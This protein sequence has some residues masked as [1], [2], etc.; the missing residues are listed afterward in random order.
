MLGNLLINIEQDPLVPRF[1]LC[2]THW[3]RRVCH[4]ECLCV[5]VT[6]EAVRVQSSVVVRR[7]KA[8]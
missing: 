3:N 8:F 2:R 4:F 7:S 5:C 6:F 1:T